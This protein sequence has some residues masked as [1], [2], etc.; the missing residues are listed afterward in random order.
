M[1]ALSKTVWILSVFSLLCSRLLL[2]AAS[3]EIGPGKTYPNIGD[4]P[5]ESLVAGDTVLIYYRA[6]AYKEKW[7]LCRQ[8]SEA[9][10]I[11]VRG[12]PDS[13]GNLP[14][15][16]GRDATTRQQL[17]YWNEDRSILKI[18]GAS[19]PPDTM[20]RHI[21]IEN[22]EIRSG[23]PPFVYTSD[24][25]AT[26]TYISNA[27]AIFIEKGEHIT[28]R[29]CIFRDCGNGFFSASQSS[30]IVVEGCY[31]YDNGNI[32]S[33]F[34]HNSYTES[35]DILF[36][37]NRY[38]PLRLGCDGNNL[39][40]RS[41]GTVIRYNWIES[42][43]RQLD[44]VDSGTS[45]FYSAP[46]YRTTFVYGNILIEP[47]GAGNSQIVHYGGDSGNAT[48]YRKGNLY[49]FNNTVVSTRSGNTTLFRLSTDDETVHC[50]N[51]IFYVAAPGNRLAILNE[52]G[53]AELDSNW[54]KTSWRTSHSN[55]S[56]TV[57]ENFGNITGDVPGFIDLA[58]QDFSLLAT[59]ICINAGGSVI[60]STFPSHVVDREYAKHQHGAVRRFDGQA[61]L[62]SYEHIL[63]TDTDQIPDWW[64]LHYFG[65]ITNAI[66]GED[67]D[68]D[69][70]LNANEFIAD[71][72]PTNPLSSFY[73]SSITYDEANRV[74]SFPTSSNRVYLLQGQ[75][76]L[77]PSG[78]WSNL[79]AFFP[80]NGSVVSV[81]ESEAT[82][83]S[84]YRVRVTFP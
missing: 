72:V 16:D 55:P 63:D 60:V 51:N 33:V 71:T 43:N 44:L 23:R 32:G 38:G 24:S 57:N 19:I 59:S 6:E 74:I 67:D 48:R 78:S 70:Q 5:W 61:D 12:V 62:G 3:Y 45:S 68:G 65:G 54:L 53:T 37:F 27:A 46:E 36:Q 39:K 42:G 15:I 81:R 9:E 31:L 14:V 47:D 25:G 80:G 40:D 21:V 4:V 69:G 82:T 7:V 50:E 26:G 10:K 49:F 83:Q 13:S 75:D 17:N 2:C 79:T 76:V 84:L 30:N 64:E 58:S 1:S 35:S 52:D 22:L 66:S 18:G 11:A 56:A 41:K 34:E 20:P 28:L 8:G 29:N 73:L 77:D